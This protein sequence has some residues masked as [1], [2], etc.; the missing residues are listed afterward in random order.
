MFWHRTFIIKFVVV[1]RTAA[2]VAELLCCSECHRSGV[3]VAAIAASLLQMIRMEI[4]WE[5]FN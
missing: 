5:T 4:D 3:A 2:G 1:L